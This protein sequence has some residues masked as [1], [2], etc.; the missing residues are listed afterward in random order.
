MSHTMFCLS[1]AFVSSWS[2]CSSSVTSPRLLSGKCKVSGISG[3]DTL[4]S[5]LP[6]R[7]LTTAVS[8]DCWCL[9]CSSSV[10]MCSS[11]TAKIKRIHRIWVSWH[12]STSG[13]FHPGPQGPLSRIF[14]MFHTHLILMNGLLWNS[15]DAWQQPFIWIR[16]VGVGI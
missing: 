4:F 9:I 12:G 7:L 15:A 5:I 11:A 6:A 1:L 2:Q 14:E 8:C 16:C 3:W 13:V 10:N